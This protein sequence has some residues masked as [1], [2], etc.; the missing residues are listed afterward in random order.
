MIEGLDNL[1]E[2]SGQVGLIELRALLHELLGGPEITGRLTNLHRLRP[3][4]YRLH[5]EVNGRGLSFVIKRFRP[6]RARLNQLVI[7]RWLPA[8][9]LSQ[10]SPPLL[11]VAAERSGQCVWHVYEDLGDWTLD[12]S[13]PDRNSVEV[14]VELFA[15]IHSR[16]AGHALLPECRL[17]GGDLGSHFYA[18]SVRDALRGLESLR[19]SDIKLL[20]DQISLRDCLLERLHKLLD[21]ES[22]R[23]NLMREFGGPETLLHGDLSRKNTLVFPTKNGLQSRLI[24]WDHAGVG[25]VS[26]DLSNFL[27]QFPTH[28]RLWILNVYQQLIQSLDWH[29]PPAQE[30]N[31]LF[32][33]AQCARLANCI[34]WH[35]IAVLKGH[36]EWGFEKLRLREQQ[37]EALEPVLPLE[38]VDTGSRKFKYRPND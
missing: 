16:F 3:R 18:W 2:G 6:E 38:Q 21:E 27:V 17:Y 30:C 23:A 24:D 10:S 5:F 8:I 12:T 19:P 36:P 15:Q 35:V 13:G 14:A 32:H 7:K 33:T 22:H 9:E 29:L 26:Y 28:E 11:G 31:L 4:V 37:F 20:P 1:L 34:I 25:P